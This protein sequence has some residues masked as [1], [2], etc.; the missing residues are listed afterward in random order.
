LKAQ[1]FFR[2]LKNTVPLQLPLPLPLHLRRNSDNDDNDGHGHIDDYEAKTNN[3]TIFK[4]LTTNIVLMNRRSLWK[5][6]TDVISPLLF[7]NAQVILTL[8]NQPQ[9]C[10]A[11]AKGAAEYDFEF[12]MRN[13]VQGNNPREGNIQATLPPP[14]PPPR[15][16]QSSS[17]SSM[18]LVEQI[19]NNDLNGDCI[20]IKTLS[21][22]TNAS[23]DD[24]AER[25]RNYRRKVAPAFA[26][27]ARWREESVIDEYYFDLTCYALYR[28]AADLIPNNYKVRD[29]WVQKL[30]KEIYNAIYTSFPSSLISTTTNSKTSATTNNGSGILKLT[31]TIPILEQILLEFQ[32]NNF[33][34]SYRLGDKKNDDVRIGSNIFDEYD[35]QD[36]DSGLSVNCLISLVRPATL[37]SS[38]QIVGEKSR[39]IPEFIGTTIAAMWR[40]E[41]GCKVEYETY[42]VDEEYRPNPKD[43]FPTEQLLQFTIISKAAL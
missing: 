36:I 32:S 8:T 18:V 12:Y 40:K 19:L 6:T 3:D 20:A 13:L 42:F 29:E 26:T 15:V 4:S 11:K 24:I 10:L 7:L 30:G 2:T 34:T 43:Y 28:T 1:P 25:I 33:I 5:R 16:L 27:R 14:L 39:F 9:P 31:D 22:V 35:N 23:I 37:T 17:K 41:L 21:Q 38:L